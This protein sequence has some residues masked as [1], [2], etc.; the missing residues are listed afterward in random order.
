M[1][2]VVRGVGGPLTPLAQYFWI[3]C[4]CVCI[5]AKTATQY[6]TNNINAYK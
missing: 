4:V 3:M 2:R 6:C 1:D 5:V